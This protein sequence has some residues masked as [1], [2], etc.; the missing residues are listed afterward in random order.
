MT[1]RYALYFAPLDDHA[2]WRFGS[3]TIGWDAE[4]ATACPPEP[5]EPA[6]ARGWETAT[7]EPRRYG[8]H[9]TLK[10][11][12]ALAEGARIDDMLDAAATF[13]ATPRVIPTLHLEARII[14]GFVALAP[15]APDAAL[16][17][18]AGSCVR[19]FDCFRAPLT[20]KDRARRAPERLTPRQVEYLDR[21][22]YPFVFEEFRFH[23][24][25]TGR[26]PPGEAEAAR[27]AL[28]KAHRAACGARRV[29]VSTLALFVQ[30]Q[31]G[32]P[33]RVLASW[34]LRSA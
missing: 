34:P 14:A 31:P 24:T 23:M 22:G 2:L 18:L 7:A 28:A 27:D 8:F 20:A 25:L 4:T 3:A 6:L 32:A 9:A 21:W 17:D 10:A 19:D 30:S 33:F 1:A 29:A 26:L 13:A 12:F 16:D 15:D 5:P 11:P